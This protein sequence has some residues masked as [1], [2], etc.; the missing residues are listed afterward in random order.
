MKRQLITW[1]LDTMKHQR[2]NAAAMVEWASLVGW[3]AG[4]AALAAVFVHWLYMLWVSADG[5]PSLTPW[6]LVGNALQVS[7]CTVV[8]VFRVCWAV[9][10]CV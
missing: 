2:P 1:L 9:V 7:G 8:R 10:R 3:S 5:V 4:A 6:P